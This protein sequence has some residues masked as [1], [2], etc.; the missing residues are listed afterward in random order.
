MLFS[1]CAG[2]TEGDIGVLHLWHKGMGYAK[3]AVDNFPVE[4][5][6]RLAT[7]ADVKQ[8]SKQVRHAY[9]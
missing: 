9:L 8:V 7:T 3:G 1:L 4:L 6:F 5:L 2:F